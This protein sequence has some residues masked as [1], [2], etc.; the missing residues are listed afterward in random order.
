MSAHTPLLSSDADVSWRRSRVIIV[1]VALWLVAMAVRGA[2]MMTARFGGDEALFFQIGMD[3]VEGKAFPLVGTPITD[4]AARLP[5]PA[6]LYL[7]AAP[8]LFWPA[9]EA[10]YLFT[11][12][13]GACTVVVWWLTARR[14]VGDPAAALSGGLLACAPWA[15]LFSDRTWNP[16][17][18]PFFVVVAMAAAWRLREVP[19]SRAALIMWPTCALLPQLHLSAPVAWVGLFFLVGPRSLRAALTSSSYRRR[20]LL[21]LLFAALLF[22]PLA[23]HEMQTG[24]ANTRHL[25]VETVGQKGGERHPWGFV[26]VPVYALRLLTTDV[27]YHEL[28]GYWGGPDE[29]RC[30]QSLWCGTE[31]RPH[32]PL[33]ILGLMASI[34]VGV[35]ACIGSIVAARRDQRAR[36]VVVAV[37]SAVVAN[38]ALMALSAK[39]VFG[40]YVIV[41]L[42]WVFL[43]V[44][45]SLR[46]ARGRWRS[47]LVVCVIVSALVGIEATSSV[48]RHVDAR[49]GLEVHRR[50]VA[51][52]DADARAR[53][54]NEAEPVALSFV[55]LYGSRFDWQVFV[56]RAAHAPWRLDP[57]ARRRRFALTPLHAA[58]P[59]GAIGAPVSLEHAL[60]W[61]L[62]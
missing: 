19:G 24:F 38:T 61:R 47:T 41:L 59:S 1:G 14:I 23:V 26:W 13:L 4:G 40:H 7:M 30:L 50:A 29:W 22:V 44:A 5:G 11:E 62:R 12:A 33:R 17:V 54:I 16:N 43:L 32:H 15:A 58:A 27:S 60:L 37:A 20:H 34:V 18:L 57:R 25:F 21:G 55:G 48:S 49:I 28:S 51:A 8:L 36:I 6:F 39:Q 10:Q 42:P 35:G 9:P 56:T 2:L 52:I 46:H 3:I 53:G 45:T 31:A